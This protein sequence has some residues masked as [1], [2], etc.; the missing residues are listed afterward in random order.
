[1][2]TES[3]QVVVARQRGAV[4]IVGLLILLVLTLL[5]VTAMKSTT[6]EERIA[7][8]DQ[9]R[10]EAFQAAEFGLARGATYDAVERCLAGDCRHGVVVVGPDQALPSHPGDA[11]QATV[12]VTMREAG[13]MPATGF[14]QGVGGGAVVQLRV[15]DLEARA[16]VQGTHARA[17][18]R[19][20]VGRIAPAQ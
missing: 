15:F 9:Y 1:M 20:R 12:T 3:R 2:E 11:G 14:S 10:T 5:G 7:A 16:T 19:M 6:L 13:T 4:L 17:V 8:N 18:H